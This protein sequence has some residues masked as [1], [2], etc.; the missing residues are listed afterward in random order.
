MRVLL[1]ASIVTTSS[2]WASSESVKGG[3]VSWSTLVWCG[4]RNKS[5][6]S[7]VMCISLLMMLGMLAYN[8]KAL[9]G[10][11]G[12][13]VVLHAMQ[14]ARKLGKTRNRNLLNLAG[15]IGMHL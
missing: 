1:P 6:G 10:S 8:A 4:A 12:R 5:M 2:G 7:D 9:G 3:A 14:S 11:S 15:T 13:N